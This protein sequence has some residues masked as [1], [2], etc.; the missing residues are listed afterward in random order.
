ML[1]VPLSAVPSQ[2]VGV[3]L[4]NQDC[5]INVYQRGPFITGYGNPINALFLDLFVAG[6][7]ILAGVLC[8]N[9]VLM[10]RSTYLGFIGDLCFLDNVG[11]NNPDFT[12]LGGRYSL[13]YLTP[14]DLANTTHPLFPQES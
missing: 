13:C 4:N 10:V 9:L 14:A 7:L 11:S 6:N 5:T 3:Q 1:I 8:L 2:T 12:G